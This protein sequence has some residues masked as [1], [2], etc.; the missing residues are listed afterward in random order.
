VPRENKTYL[1]SDKILI[2]MHSNFLTLKE[3]R[4]IMKQK[5]PKD[6][7]CVIFC[8]TTIAFTKYSN[9]LVHLHLFSLQVSCSTNQL[10]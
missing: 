8:A 6:T 1:K 5:L 3:C 10:K 7:D 2:K 9:F 4:K